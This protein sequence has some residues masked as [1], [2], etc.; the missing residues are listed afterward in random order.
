MINYNFADGITSSDTD[1]I[2]RITMKEIIYTEADKMLVGADGVVI[3]PTQTLD[4]KLSIPTETYFDPEEITE[5]SESSYKRLEAF[6]KN[7]NLTKYQTR[8]IITDEAKARQFEDEQV[9]LSLDRARNGF[10]RKKDTD[11]FTTLSAGAGD[12]VSA[13]A[14]WDG[15]SASITD[16]VADAMGSIFENTLVTEQEAQNMILYFPATMVGQVAKPDDVGTM[17]VNLKQWV[18]STLGI[19]MR[20]TRQLSTTALLVSPGSETALH[21]VYTG[22]AVPTVEQERLSGTGDLYTFTQYF[23]TVVVPNSSS[24]DTNS[25]IVKITGVDS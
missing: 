5:G 3:R 1:M 22:N 4:L 19:T 24:D 21:Y 16:D 10:V 7:I 6:D 9:R 17:G 25:H 13:T 8:M 18:N 12:T 20:P 23:K 14:E 11:I 15:D 2:K